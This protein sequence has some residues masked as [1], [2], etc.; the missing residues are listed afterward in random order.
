MLACATQRTLVMEPG[1]AYRWPEALHA[2]HGLGDYPSAPNALASVEFKKLWQMAI[3]E[4][5]RFSVG[6]QDVETLAL[7]RKPLDVTRRWVGTDYSRGRTDTANATV[8]RLALPSED[9]VVKCVNASLCAEVVADWLGATVI[10]VTRDLRK[11]V[12]SWTLLAGFEPEELHADPW[13]REHVLKGIEIPRLTTRLEKIA[14]TVA[15]LHRSLVA[16]SRRQSWLTVSY[17]QLLADPHSGIVEL[18]SSCGMHCDDR[19]HAFIDSRQQPGTGF[20]TKRSSE[21]LRRWQERLTATEWM[22][23][24]AVLGHFAA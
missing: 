21:Q 24:D 14:W 11:V 22:Q 20:E 6:R 18:V 3:E 15:T 8:H 1:D 2:K 13:V 16:A 10:V 12:S 9:I 7:A 23:V 19:V 17:E 5:R 4:P